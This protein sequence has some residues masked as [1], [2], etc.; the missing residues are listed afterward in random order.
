MYLVLFL[1]SML[2]GILGAWVIK[3]HGPRFGFV[4]H[5]NIRSSHKSPTPKGGG[6]GILAAFIFSALIL[7][8]SYSFWVPTTFLA[9]MSFLGD[10][11]D[12]SP[13]SRLPF[14]F[15]AAFFLLLP[16][17]DIWPLSSI[18]YFLFLV[19]FITATANWY[20]FM[21][22]IDGIAGIAG[23]VG[24]SL[25]AVFNTINA[26]DNRFTVLLI[27]ITLSC[28]GFLPF[29]IPEAKV[30]MGDVGSI[31]LGF[32][33]AA[34]V[35]ILSKS[36]FDFVCLAGF[37]FPFYAD[38][39][40]TMAIRIKDGENL[41]KPHRRHFYQILTNEMGISH[42]KVSIGY[43]IL[44]I[45]V[46]IS[47]LLGR[48]FGLYTVLSLLFFFFCGFILINHIVRIRLLSK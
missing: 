8:I 15:I 13:R 11:F 48:T 46:G 27:C 3:A 35:I 26:G 34:M 28:L 19:L 42:W 41:L 23:I 9:L 20:N 21:D 37:L 33:F 32:I 43:G 17:F 29:N 10:R 18:L 12:L 6:I 22:G 25:L 5:P 47:V 4:D 40:I 16:I 30:F 45:T 1:S 2:F 31:M 39:F 38:E 36:F 44:Q 7:K 24:F 14:Q